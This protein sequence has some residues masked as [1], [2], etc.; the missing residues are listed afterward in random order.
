VNGFAV[1]IAF[2]FLLVFFFYA[3]KVKQLACFIKPL[4]LFTGVCLNQLD[5][6]LQNLV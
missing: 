1:A 2:F 4:V 3:F 5:E 6:H